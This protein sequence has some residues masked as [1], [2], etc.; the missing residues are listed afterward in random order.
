MVSNLFIRAESIEVA[1]EL[2][3]SIPILEFGG[4][5]EV[6]EIPKDRQIQK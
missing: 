2:S 5:I 6:R 1:V 4:T 3:K